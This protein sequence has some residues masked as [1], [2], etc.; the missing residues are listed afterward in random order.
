MIDFSNTKLHKLIVHKVGN[1]SREE[2]TVL[3]NNNLK[4]QGE[5][6]NDL[7]LQFFIKPFKNENFFGFHHETDLNLNE[8]Y[9]F[10]S[11]IFKE[12]Q[13]FVEQ[14]QNIAKHL[15]EQSTH[16]KIKNGEFYTI[17]LKDCLIEDELV[18][19]I[20]LFKTENKDTYIKVKEKDD[21]FEIDYEK[22]ININ[23]LDKACIIFNTEK[24][25]GY[26][27]SIIDNIN[28]GGE[29][30]YWKDDFLKIKPREDNYYFTQNYLNMCKDFADKG[31][32]ELDKTEQI[33]IKNSTMSYFVE[34]DTFNIEEFKEEVIKDE[35]T[36]EIFNEFVQNYETEN[37][38]QIQ[39]EFDIS[40]NAVKSVKRKFKSII[41][42]DKN[43]H[44]YI[45]G[46]QDL[47]EKGYDEQKNKNFYKLFFDKEK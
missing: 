20:G 16:P 14:S 25:S 30:Q 12:E 9:F 6:L 19:A 44:I 4:L 47:I 35:E 31:L 40:K 38:L 43:F 36:K 29:A 8:T 15:Y 28:K 2:G 26:I 18:D 11:E 37:D 7:M 13:S 17:I 21:N 32:E 39:N 42:L 22:G 24:D 3:S 46:N 41:K 27:V 45:H 33:D 10:A 5:M 1:K 34:K 23:K